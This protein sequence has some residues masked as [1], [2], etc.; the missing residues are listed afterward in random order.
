MHI[1]L[2][3]DYIFFTQL[4]KQT[5]KV[6]VKLSAVDAADCNFVEVQ[7]QFVPTIKPLKETEKVQL[8]FVIAYA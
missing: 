7:Q 6:L 1:L 8:L 5:Q 2:H 3:K 4:K